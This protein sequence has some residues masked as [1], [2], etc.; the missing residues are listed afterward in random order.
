MAQM[1]SARE[2]KELN[3][4]DLILEEGEHNQCFYV[5]LS[6]SVDLSQ[7]GK[8]VRT[9]KEG[10]IFGLE[11]HFLHRP[12]YLRARAASKS[13]IAAYSHEVLN[14]IYSRPQMVERILGSLLKQL[15][16]T[17]Q[18][19]LESG[20][21]DVA[22][23][24]MRFVEDGEVIISEGEL[25]EEV[26]KLVSAEGG[27]RVTRGDKHLAT[28][29][30]PEEIFGEMSGILHQPRSA[31]IVSVGRSVVQ[32]YPHERMEELIEENPAFARKLI[33]RLAARLSEANKLVE[34]KQ[35]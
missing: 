19:A 9:L 29:S 16:Q 1:V 27:L 2:V 4:G 25:G 30:Q 17:S 13:R 31:T 26:F 32:V 6:G 12:S 21:A 14:D 7:N 33:E 22:D 34:K 10:D 20:H 3:G 23:V 28:I 15:E 8:T 11:S 24:S 5:I 18:V 35:A